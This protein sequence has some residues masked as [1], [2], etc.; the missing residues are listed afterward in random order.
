MQNV[1]NLML[2]VSIYIL[3]FLHIGSF[4]WRLV[5]TKN[6]VDNTTYEEG[7]PVLTLTYYF[8][9]QLPF[10]ML[11]FAII[12][13]IYQWLEIKHTLIFVLDLAE[14]HDDEEDDELDEDGSIKSKIGGL[15]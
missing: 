14:Y 5:V 8:Y 10:D 1:Y 3:L 7:V 11:N 9:Y 6:N 4:I 13:H 2:S 12:T 15:R